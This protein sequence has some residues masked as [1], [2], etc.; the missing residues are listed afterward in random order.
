LALE[1]SGNWK[2]GALCAKRTRG[3]TAA[4]L[5]STPGFA[6]PLSV[7][8]LARMEP[9]ATCMVQEFLASRPESLANNSATG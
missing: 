2:T 9:L 5:G 4:N 6:L 3:E 7:A 8:G 1:R